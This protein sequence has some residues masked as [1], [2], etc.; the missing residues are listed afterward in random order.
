MERN[1]AI[2]KK[3]VGV[4]RKTARYKEF[5]WEKS[6]AVL[7]SISIVILALIFLFL[8]KDGIPLFRHV[9]VAEFLF[10]DTWRPISE[11][12]VFGILPLIAGS[13]VVTLAAAAMS[14][15]MGVGCAIYIAEIADPRAKEFLKVVVELIAGIPSVVLGF[16]GVLTLAPF[17][18][19]IFDLP[20]GLTAFTGAVVLA[21]MAVPT[22]ATISEDA[23]YSVPREYR[24]ASLAM[25]ATRWQTIYKV[26]IPASSSGILAASLLGV[27]RVIGE[28]M[29]VMMVCGNAPV[30]PNTIFQPV[31]TMTATIAAEMGETVHG[32]DHYMALFAVGLA[33][34]AISFAI[35]AAAS[36]AARRRGAGA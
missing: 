3:P 31:R 26:I 19:E 10:G 20:T 17:V 28:T 35:N 1:A 22:I 23:I 8:V 15:P 2:V 34:F 18:Q 32:G 25:G 33:L 4:K 27:G 13:I 24:E 36:G 12:P 7:G 14:V 30:I 29:V 16:I 11:P 5:A 21:F 6:I 9:G